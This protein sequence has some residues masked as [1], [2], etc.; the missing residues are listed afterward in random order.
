MSKKFIQKSFL[1]FLVLTGS[2]LFSQSVFA[3]WPLGTLTLQSQQTF[4]C[5]Q[6][7][8]CKR[9]E[10][11]CPAVEQLASGDLA[12]GSARGPVRGLIMLF[13]G[14]EG[15]T[16]WTTEHPQ[17]REFAEQLRSTGFVVVQVKWN[18]SWLLSSAG[19]QA[20]LAHLACRPATV[21]KY[22]YQTYYL[23]LGLKRNPGVAGFA[24]TGNSGGASQVAY[25]LSHYGLD[26]ILDVVIPTGGPPHATLAKSC[27]NNLPQKPYWFSLQTR[28]FIDKG[29]GF[30]N[31]SGPCALQNP[32]YLPRWIRE[33]VSTGGNDY[34]HPD[35]RVSFIVGQKDPLML[36]I[37]GDY[38][39]RLRNASSPRVTWRVLPNTG[40]QIFIT[41]EGRNALLNAILG[42]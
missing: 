16:W 42:K 17:A 34:Y 9:F 7:Y 33:S 27:M 12:V 40:H 10:V 4:N 41:Q 18:D 3:Y 37:A 8:S 26:R 5:P 39:L 20:G 21:I 30:L 11:R 2:L 36:R 19:N 28:Q 6:G 1:L 25:A 24:V 13:T 38:L 15:K 29:F 14:G 35:T 31:A 22:V 32:L 23:P